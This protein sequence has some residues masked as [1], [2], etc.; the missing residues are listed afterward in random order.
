MSEVMD[1]AA[2]TPVVSEENEGEEFVVEKIKLDGIISHL[3][4][5]A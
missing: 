2:P 1:E 3:L 5:L 4:C